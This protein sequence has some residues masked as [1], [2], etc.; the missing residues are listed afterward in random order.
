[1]AKAPINVSIAGDYN[2]KNINRAIRDL[3][4]LKT[5]G[6]STTKSMSGLSAGM[7]KMGIAAGIA[8]A[9]VAAMAVKFAVDAIVS[10]SDLNETMSKAQVIFGDAAQGI[11]EFAETANTS[12]G[13]TKQQAIDAAAT[14]AIFGKS[15]GLTGTD[16]QNFSTDLVSLSADL[17]SFHNAASDE[18]ITAL[19][20]ALRGE[21]EPMRRFGV[22]LND[23]S[24]K[25]QAMAMGIYEG[26]GSLRR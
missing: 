8:A 23:A 22:L 24:L 21:A 20:S 13:Q 16:L 5:G 12:L 14:F 17:G 25:A 11:F 4:S 1:V 2:D 6:A 10:A 26:T 3:N 15:A 18:V 7:A 9:A 19:G